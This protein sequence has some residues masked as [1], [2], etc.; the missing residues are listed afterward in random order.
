MFSLYQ[1]YRGLSQYEVILKQQES[2]AV[3][4]KPHAMPRVM[5]LTPSG[6]SKG[7]PGDTAPMRALAPLRPLPIKLVVR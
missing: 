3:T 6:G 1:V 4:G 2:R 5:Y 7:W